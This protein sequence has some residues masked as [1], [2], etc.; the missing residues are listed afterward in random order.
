VTVI[1][2]GAPVEPHTFTAREVFSLAGIT[3]RQ[4]DYWTRAGY[5]G[6]CRTAGDQC[7]GTGHQ[8]AYTADELARVAQIACLIR[9]GYRADVAARLAAS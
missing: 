5:L 8:R 2:I 3:Y 6:D 9:A 1:D 7:P 4:L